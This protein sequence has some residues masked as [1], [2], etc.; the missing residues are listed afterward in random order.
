MEPRG[1][2]R[3]STGRKRDGRGSRGNMRKALPSVATSCV[4]RSMVSV[5]L[6]PAKEGV[7]MA[8]L[9]R[10][11]D[12]FGHEC[13]IASLRELGGADPAMYR[14]TANTFEDPNYYAQHRR[15]RRSP[16][17]HIQVTGRATRVRSPCHPPL[18]PAVLPLRATQH[19]SATGALSGRCAETSAISPFRQSIVGRAPPGRTSRRCR[20]ASSPA[21][22]R[23]GVAGAAAVDLDAGLEFLARSGWSRPGRRG[24]RAGTTRCSAV[25]HRR[26]RA[27]TGAAR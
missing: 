20:G 9:G 1:C 2:N 6:H 11:I 25:L 7:V 22:R 19:R 15:R 18:S 3:W 12:S 5:D 17:A 26:E 23:T 27:H 4:S 21:P 24:R 10:I 14:T 16:Q 13:E 8:G